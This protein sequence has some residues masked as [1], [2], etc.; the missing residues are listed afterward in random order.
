MASACIVA[1]GTCSASFASESENEVM[2]IG[3]KREQRRLERPGSTLVITPEAPSQSQTSNH[4]QRQ[5]SMNVLDTGLPSPSGFLIPRIRGQDAAV[6]EVWLEDMRLQDPYSG[7]PMISDLDLNAFGRLQLIQ[8]LSSPDMPSVNPFGA[9]IYQMRRRSEGALQVGASAG[10]PYGQSLWGRAAIEKDTH[11]AILYARH[12]TTNGRYEFYDDNGT[13]ENI[14][15]DRRRTRT[16]SHQTSQQLLPHIEARWGP[17]QARYMALLAKGEQGLP[18]MG[19]REETQAEV[20]KRSQLHQIRLARQLGEATQLGVR[21][22]V[23]REERD[24]FDPN[25]VILITADRSK[26]KL[27]SFGIEVFGEHTI[28]ANTLHLVGRQQSATLEQSL[29]DKNS[30]PAEARSEGGYL[31]VDGAWSR[32]QWEGKIDAQRLSYLQAS[33]VR[34]NYFSGSESLAVGYRHSVAQTTFAQLASVTRPPTILHTFGDGE[35]IG[36]SLNLNAEQIQHVELGHR[37]RWAAPWQVQLGMFRD[38]YQDKLVFIPSMG[39]SLR[40]L[41]LRHSRIT[42]T[43]VHIDFA[44]QDYG[45][46]AAATFMEP[47][48]LS[49][50]DRSQQIPGISRLQATL[51]LR[52]TWQSIE[53]RWTSRYRD[54]VFRDVRNTISV[55]PGWVHQVSL[56]RKFAIGA[57]TVTASMTVDNVLNQMSFPYRTSSGQEGR[58]AYQEVPGYPLPGRGWRL[59]L[60]GAF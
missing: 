40:A 42:G 7:L 12:F 54:D 32:M 8:G 55:P 5:S 1:F 10:K 34:R 33:G 20:E 49:S 53:S 45:A 37:W 46:S 44:Q 41:N 57:G 43:E 17:W 9:M 26:F 24:T 50:P 30:A 18:S 48:D 39:Q 58:S 52:A 21:S 6:S 51:S 47:L 15:D 11:S 56:D 3:Q 25:Q 23:R 35:R 60:V 28:G 22:I 27:D 2:V 14:R 4:L 36:S 19:G 31:A 38:L 29:N 13:P 16:D 59:S